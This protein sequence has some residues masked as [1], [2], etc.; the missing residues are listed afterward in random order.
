MSAPAPSRAIV[1]LNAYAKNLNAVRARIPKECGIVAVI[2]ADAYGH[3]AVQVARKAVAEGVRMVAVAAVS[4]AIELREAG[5]EAPVLLLVQPDADALAAAI[6][7]NVRLMI[8]DVQTAER[9]GEL[10]R[11]ANKVVPI[12]CKI[13]TGMGRQGFSSET[14][15]RDLLSLTK[16]SHV[17]IEGIATHF[18]VAD[19]TRDSFTST[20]LRVFRQVLRQIEKEG[21]PYEMAHAANSGGVVNHE[22][23]TFDMVRVGLMAYGVWP[24]DTPPAA[25]VLTPVL[26]WESKIVLIKELAGGA[27]IGYGRTFTT[28]EASR[29]GVVPVGYADGYPLSLSN[30]ASVLVR[31]KRCPVRGRVSMDQIVVELNDVP[32]ASCGDAVTIIGSDGG[33]S[34]TAAELAERGGTIPYEILTGIGK[35]VTREYVGVVKEH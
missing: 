28:H 24:S 11:K 23:S 31:G 7:A 5:I 18:A 30:R 13:D 2:K 19:S 8:S 15:V 34:I 9:L 1:D 25:H 32:N 14:A 20:Q 10:A 6:E 12:H 21:I 29:V 22:G 33:E 4:E 27:S 16:I 3:G 35:R 26:R 17:D